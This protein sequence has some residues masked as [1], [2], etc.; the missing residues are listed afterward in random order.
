LEIS[1]ILLAEAGLFV[2]FYGMPGERGWGGCVGGEAVEDAFC[3]F[4][5][6]AVGGGEE[7][8]GV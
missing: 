7:V 2:D 1:E 4:P 5:R 6:A 3:C 8:E